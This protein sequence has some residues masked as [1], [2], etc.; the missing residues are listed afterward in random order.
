MS[1]GEAPYD[2]HLEARYIG[3]DILAAVTGG[4]RSH[5]GAVALAEPAGALHPVT[6]ETIRPSDSASAAEEPADCDD[7]PRVSVMDSAGHKDA[8]L[9]EMF[10]SSL[11]ALYEVNVCVAA[12]VHVDDAG[13]DEIALMLENAKALLDEVQARSSTDN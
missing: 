8:V 11:C 6:G 2:I 9:A 5:I 4:T 1:Y 13:K 12:G 7:R 3:E 10:A